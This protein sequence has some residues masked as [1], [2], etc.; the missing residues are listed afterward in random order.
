MKDPFGRVVDYLRVSVTD[1]CNYRCNY[2][3]AEDMTFLPRKELL[4]LEELERLCAVFI[5]LG[6]KKLRIT[7][8][9]PLVRRD[10]MSLFQTLGQHLHQGELEELTLTTNGALLARHAQAL[11][12]AGV[13]RINV[14]LDTLQEGKFAEITRTGRYHEVMDGIEAA[15]KAGLKVKINTVALKGVNDDELNALVG[16]CG[17]KGYDLSMIESMPMGDVGEMRSDT[18]LALDE[19]QKTLSNDWTLT[20]STKTTAG[21][22][23]YVNVGET[24]Q[25]VGFISPY[26]HN[27]CES[28]NRVRLTCTGTLYLCLGQDDSVDLREPLRAGASNEELKRVILEAIERKPKGHDFDAERLPDGAQV[29]RFMSTTGG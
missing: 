24:N 26:S 19:V 22:A 12:Q 11:F 13:K 10:V 27:F 4:S 9:E 8:G 2:C 16:W 29:V 3:M 23:R 18:F 14:S 28:C 17:D 6:V 1:R 5:E 15:A 7:G 20:T 21:P 25:R